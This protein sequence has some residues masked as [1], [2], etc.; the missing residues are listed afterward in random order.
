MNVTP[1]THKV[2]AM[3]LLCLALT[4]LATAAYTNPPLNPTISISDPCTCLNNATTL[5]NGQFSETIQVTATTGQNWT[6]IS[7][8]GFYDASSPIPPNIP[9]VINAGTSLIEAP[10][11]SG[12]FELEGTLVD[13]NP[14]VVTV[15]NGVGEQLSISNTCYYPN[16]EMLNLDNPI[17]LNTNPILL[18]AEA[19]GATGDTI[20]TING[21]PETTFDPMTLGVGTHYVNLTFDAGIATPNDPSDPGCESSILKLVQVVETPEVLSCDN[22][23]NVSLNQNCE[24]LIT[25]DMLLEGTYGC[26]D[27][28]LVSIT[29]NFD[30]VPNPVSGNYI[31][32]ELIGKV[33]HLPSGNSCWGYLT[34]EDKQ[35][36]VLNCVDFTIE[37]YQNPDLIPAPV[38]VDNCDSNPTENLI[39]EVID[40]SDPC[41]GVTVTRTWMAYDQYFNVSDTCQQIITIAPAP[42]PNFPTDRLWTCN[43]Y[44]PYPTVLDATP[45]TAYLPT[46]GSGIPTNITGQYCM[47]N[48]QSNDQIIQTCG[49]TF[50]VIRTWTVLNWCTGQ[51]VTQGAA[52]E[53]NV[54]LI[55]VADVTPPIISQNP[56]TVSANVNGAHP[57]PCRSQ[58]F[59]PAAEVSDECSAYSLKI[60]TPVGEAVYQNGVNGLSGGFIPAPGLDQG[61]HTITYRAEDVCGNVSE[62]EVEIEV[63][64]DIAPNAI[65]DQLTTVAISSAGE[66]AVFASVFDDGSYD[67]CG[68][69]EMTVRRLNDNCGVSSN[70]EFGE[71]IT[72]CCADASQ[73]PHEVEM[74]VVDYNGN[75][76]IC[77]IQVLVEDQQSPQTIFC[78][79]NQSVTCDFYLDNLSVPL[80]LNDYSVLDQFGTP[81]F[82]D[83]CD[84]SVNQNVTINIDQCGNGSITRT[85]QAT[86]PSG[87]GPTTCTQI[88]FTE[89]VSDWVIE[90]PDDLIVTCEDD[91][92]DFGEPKITFETCELLAYSFEDDTFNIVPD[93]CFKIVRTWTAINW[94]VVGDNIDEETFEMSESELGLPFPDCDL[95]G[96][97]DCDNLTFQDSRTNLGVSD[98][99]A[100]LDN[101][102]GYISFQQSIKVIDKIAPEIT[103]P[104][105]IEICI[106]SDDCLT[107]VEL[108]Q[109]T[110]TDC[111]T[112]LTI[113]A[114]SSVGNGFGPFNTVGQGNILVIYSATDN[115]GNTSNCQIELSV[116]DCK[117]P[118]PKCKNGLIVELMDNDPPSIEIW[119]SDFDDGSTDNCSS[120]VNFS[121]SSD[122][123]D[124]FIT[125]E[126]GDVGQQSLEI[127]V[128]DDAGNQDYCTTFVDI[129]DNMLLC[130]DP[131]V[132]GGSISTEMGDGISEVEVQLSGT[133]VPN[134]MTDVNGIYAFVDVEQDYDY[135]VIPSKD[136]EPL[137]GVTTYDMVL[138]RKHILNIQN[139]DSPYKL[140]A[141]DVN[142]SGTVTTSDLVQIKK[143]ILHI[144]D[145]FSNNTSWRFVPK[146]YEFPDSTNPGQP[147]EVIT[148]NN[149]SGDIIDADFIGIKIGDVNNSVNPNNLFISDDRKNVEKVFFDI[150]NFEISRGE[151]CEIGFKIA[152][153]H[154]IAGFQFS[155]N[156]DQESVEFIDI[157]ETEF[158]KRE[159]F[160]LAKLEYG[161]LT[162]SW[163]NLEKFSKNNESQILFKLKFKA[164]KNTEI[165]GLFDL[166][167]TFTKTEAYR[168]DG[169]LIDLSLR[170]NETGLVFDYGGVKL[171]QNKPNPFAQR[172]TISFILPEAGHVTIS[173]VDITGKQLKD[174]TKHLKKG[175][176][177]LPL[178][179]HELGESGIYFC[180]L[181]TEKA[182]L[183]RKMVFILD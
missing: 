50:K 71:T 6:V 153:L 44:T 85:F 143:L 115:C 91:L 38:A 114:L 59:L 179:G 108:P 123:N 159:N 48:V 32:F 78:P 13:G 82:K 96:D 103:C 5:D 116:I 47:H 37:C 90:F 12:I 61:I 39:S 150:D 174:I 1:L 83:N 145:E 100:D 24:A 111:S 11:G 15:Q 146:V 42:L 164:L 95:D 166:N 75:Y 106:E 107:T 64:D 54:Q 182:T 79:T 138:I 172:T 157:I 131:L 148:I 55:E 113:H 40:N 128:T 154:E 97:G 70:T 171:N 167:S 34:V 176:H 51:L 68:I 155:L 27:D 88:I 60:Y 33:T 183:T 93:A 76:N 127:W 173:F 152:N 169:E 77:S 9:I 105:P 122:I 137:N 102:D 58:D 147:M 178:F 117:K 136:I 80:D 140:I 22:S 84:F 86:D 133:V 92:P 49:N 18:E 99:D 66:A 109:P 156:F 3:A 67:N 72:F 180:R 165:K 130:T 142:N 170:L 151:V 7:A 149:L 10:G 144:D 65:C 121:F 160:G 21:H 89:H 135:T 16:I 57:Q 181:K 63:I 163:F 31:G 8:F 45:F 14:Y 101:W 177:E 161:T 28:Y 73:I 46:T 36:P 134:Q 30:T 141:A 17:C 129:Q 124:R 19:F 62:L 175:Y 69:L 110:V 4:L 168:N 120:N 52:G 81:Q 126:C 118:S 35:P 25:P 158:V 87:N 41:V 26:E 132:M 112:D 125:Y 23:I 43:E 104:D 29:H 94:C 98:T 162:S 119:A 74:M 56:F 139:L 53:D 20:F 2:R